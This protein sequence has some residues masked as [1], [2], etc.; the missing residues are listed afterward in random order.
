M[1]KTCWNE[2]ACRNSIKYSGTYYLTSILFNPCIIKARYHLTLLL[3]N[4]IPA[5]AITNIIMAVAKWAP[6]KGYLINMSSCYTLLVLTRVSYIYY[7]ILPIAFH[8]ECGFR[9]FVFRS[10]RDLC[11]RR[12]A[13]RYVTSRRKLWRCWGQWERLGRGFLHVRDHA[14]EH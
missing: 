7:N 13:W 8:T 2:D 3:F 5:H 10:L 14:H 6:G 12:C 11:W 4:I 1:K 9:H